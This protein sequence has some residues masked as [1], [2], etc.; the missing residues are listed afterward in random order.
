M[1]PKTNKYIIGIGLLLA[2]S[3]ALYGLIFF[4]KSQYPQ[5]QKHSL[6]KDPSKI[7]EIIKN[8]S[9]IFDWKCSDIYSSNL[10]DKDI[11]VCSYDINTLDK[12]QNLRTT[13]IIEGNKLYKGGIN[14]VLLNMEE[15]DTRAKVFQKDVPY[16]IQLT[17]ALQ[18]VNAFPRAAV[19]L[20]G[21][22]QYPGV[23]KVDTK[24]DSN[25][26]C[27][28]RYIQGEPFLLKIIGYLPQDTNETKFNIKTLQFPSEDNS[29]P[30]LSTLNITDI[31]RQ[32]IEKAMNLY[33]KNFAIE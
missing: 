5:R 29:I 6:E 9:E 7:T 8:Y 25:L 28:S 2:M 16:C 31:Y 1:S 11:F 15:V 22:K 33:E 32:Y 21:K 4:Q 14:L 18:S 10:K 23:L 20:D 12:E 17:P 27:V 3:L 26:I 19:S 24:T 13:N 30:F